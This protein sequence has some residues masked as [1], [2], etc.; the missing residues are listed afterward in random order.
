MARNGELSRLAR[1]IT[2][3]RRPNLSP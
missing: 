3:A 2:L 1:I